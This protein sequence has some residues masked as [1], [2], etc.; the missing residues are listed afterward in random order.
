MAT[1]HIVIFAN[2]RRIYS[3]YQDEHRSIHDFETG[4][5]EPSAGPCRADTDAGG[6]GKDCW[7]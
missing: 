6:T 5:Y 2:A 1:P 7:R 3:I 4:Q